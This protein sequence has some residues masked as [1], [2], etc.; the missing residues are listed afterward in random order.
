[1]VARGSNS[2]WHSSASSPD[3]APKRLTG[4]A[5][6]A[7]RRAEASEYVDQMTAAA[8]ASA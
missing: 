6:A 4:G 5:C 2:R 3:T 1:M 8:I 7:P